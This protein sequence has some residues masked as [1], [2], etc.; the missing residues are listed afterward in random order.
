VEFASRKVFM[1]IIQVQHLNKIQR[2][3]IIT[4]VDICNNYESLEKAIYL[5]GSDDCMEIDNFYLLYQNQRLIS[6]IVINPVEEDIIEVIEV[7]GYTLPEFRQKGYFKYLLNKVKEDLCKYPNLNI[8]FV[9]E[10]KSQSALKTMEAL[11]KRYMK[12]EYLLKINMK[13]SNIKPVSRKNLN[14]CL[15]NSNTLKEAVKVN[16]E[17]LSMEKEEAEYMFEEI[18]NAKDLEYYCAYYEGE[19]I[20]VCGLSYGEHSASVF[21]FGVKEKYQGFGFGRELL[22]YLIELVSKKSY[23][24]ITL[25][26]SSLSGKALTLYEHMG[27]YIKSQYDYYQ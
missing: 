16:M 11:N 21:G 27:F 17:T 6:L 25:H 12:S 14:I 1:E 20:G 15:L 19:L 9:M 10:A 8:Q 2:K 13:D 3:E 24:F 26:V 18:L 23:S 5:D 22:T 4:L 7:C